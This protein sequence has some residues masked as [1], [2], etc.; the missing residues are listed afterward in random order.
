MHVRNAS[1][2]L[3]FSSLIFFAVGLKA[4]KTINPPSTVTGNAWHVTMS[5]LLAP[6]K[7][8][9]SASSIPTNDG[10]FVL[11]SYERPPCEGRLHIL[12]LDRN[13]EGSLILQSH[14]GKQMVESEYILQ[15]Q[16][17]YNFPTL[18]FWWAQTQAA[19]QGTYT[20]QRMP[21]VWAVASTAACIDLKS[22]D[23]RANVD[24]S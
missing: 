17:Y 4:I 19:I 15:G 9:L 21:R 11:V 22:I 23:W 6:Q 1:Y 10:N 18:K 3:L 14:L 20:N 5:E 12:P 2:I 8:R 7:F 24:H 16:R 13:S